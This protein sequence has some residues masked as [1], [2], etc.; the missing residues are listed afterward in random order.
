[1][2]PKC[3]LGVRNWCLKAAFQLLALPMLLV[4]LLGDGTP[5][6]GRS[7][8]CRSTCEILISSTGPAKGIYQRNMYSKGISSSQGGP[9]PRMGPRWAPCYVDSRCR[10]STNLRRVPEEEDPSAGQKI[11]IY[12][13]PPRL[14]LPWPPP[15]YKRGVEPPSRARGVSQITPLSKLPDRLLSKIRIKGEIQN[16]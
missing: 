8:A 14:L 13:S 10:G 9:N 2:S 15:G 7:S 6:L 3:G 5:G 12:N 16:K 1:M 4:L 11:F